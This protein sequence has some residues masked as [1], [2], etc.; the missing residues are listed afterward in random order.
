MM[1]LLEQKIAAEGIIRDNQIIQVDSFLNHQMDTA[2]YR[3]IGK[4]FYRIFKDCGITKIL[5]IEASGIGL[6][7]VTAQNFG[8]NAVFAKKAAQKTL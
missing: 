3:E 2:L 6:A 4:E 5:T 8:V 1:K 7:C